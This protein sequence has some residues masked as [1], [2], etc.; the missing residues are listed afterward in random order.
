[1]HNLK[2]QAGVDYLTSY[3]FVILFIAIA[4]YVVLQLGVL[5]YRV[6]PEFCN[7]SPYLNCVSYTINTIGAMT[8]IISQST[9]GIMDIHG[10]ACSSAI[11]T[12]GNNPEFGNVNV[13]PYSDTN[14]YYPN[15]QFSNTIVLYSDTEEEFSLYCYNANGLASSNLGNVFTGYLWLNYTYSELPPTSNDIWEVASM[16]MKY[17]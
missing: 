14:N 8:V 10:A 9:G 6:E 13:V 15:A 3:G 17:T 2:S 5:N 11:N 4:A 12:T 1:M 16:S 7:P